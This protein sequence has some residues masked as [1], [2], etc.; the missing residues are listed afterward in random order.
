MAK[1]VCLG[2]ALQD[3]FL[4]DRDDFA[5]ATIGDQSIFS[6]L[7]IG[8]KVDIDRI[9]YQTGGGATNSAAT[10]ARHGHSVF[11]IGNLGRDAAGNFIRTDLERRGIDTSF[12]QTTS[13][14]TGSSIVLL[15]QKSGE[16][17]I[18]THRG[19]S[20]SFHNL[21]PTTLD[22]IHPDWLYITSLNG[23]LQT[24]TNFAKTAKSHGTKIFWNPG[25]K[26]LANLPGLIRLFPYVDIILL[27]KTEAMQ[28]VAGDSLEDLIVSLS[29][30]LKTII[31]TDGRNGG[32]ATDHQSIYRFGLYDTRPTKDAT[33]AGDAFGSGFLARFTNGVSLKSAL[34]FASANASSV[35]AKIG[36]KPGILDPSSELSPFPIKK[37][38][39]DLPARIVKIPVK[40][41]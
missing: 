27:N 15:D 16:R 38:S 12:S 34:I 32:I 4:I 8:T 23:D 19:A 41:H 25:A 24:L 11:F 33:G 2:S 20:K 36:A 26:E 9:S 37:L 10:L 28:I 29:A 21:S 17:T 18:L 31:I 14:A 35:V 30:Y 40:R 22:I 5:S 13:S 6:K 39:L 7:L 3:I 1:I